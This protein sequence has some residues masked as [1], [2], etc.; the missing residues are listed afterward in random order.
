MHDPTQSYSGSFIIHYVEK[1]VYINLA[2]KI[3]IVLTIILAVVSL[4]IY[5][6]RNKKP[7]V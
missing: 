5:S 7:R 2:P 3:I 6:P 1:I 4:W